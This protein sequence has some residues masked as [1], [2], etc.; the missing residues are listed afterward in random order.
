ML[1]RFSF[2]VMKNDFQRSLAQQQVLFIFGFV[3][4][5]FLF[6]FLAGHATGISLSLQGTMQVLR[7]NMKMESLAPVVLCLLYP[8]SCPRSL[9]ARRPL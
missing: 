7:G 6:I 4:F 5:L 9:L 8:W 3:D 1:Q 2:R